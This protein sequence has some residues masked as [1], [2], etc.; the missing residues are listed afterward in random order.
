MTDI[1][2]K[3]YRLQVGD[4]Y[5]VLTVDG[6]GDNAAQIQFRV[7]SH[8]DSYIQNAEFTV[9]GLSREQRRR[10]YERYTSVSFVAGYENSYG[11]IF[12]GTIYNVGIGRD[13]PEVFVRLYCRAVNETWEKA[14]INKSWGKGTPALEII[15][16]VAQ[17]F[18]YPLEFVGDFSDLPKTLKGT[19]FSESS[20]SAM[21]KLANNYSFSWNI[22]GGS[23]TIARLGASRQG[24]N[25]IYTISA[26]TGMVGTPRVTQYGIDVTSRMNI[27]ISLYDNVEVENST[28]EIVVNNPNA[29]SFPDTIG[30]GIY[31]T[32]GVTHSGDYEGDSWE[33]TIKGWAP[34]VGQL[35]RTR[36][37]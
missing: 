23:M 2:G 14:S 34:R 20:K 13:G 26:E 30:A 37:G 27:N 1:W 31:L 24:N 33:T 35:P 5:E 6:F 11:E 8:A 36:G 19:T 3:V 16:G 29:A 12:N 22:Y 18:G 25:A 28:A 9:Y 17:T 10:F 21:R 32:R 15:R 7:E 4:D